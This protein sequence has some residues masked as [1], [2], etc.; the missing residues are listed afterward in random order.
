MENLTAFLKD[1]LYRHGA[2]VVGIG[3][4]AELPPAVREQLPFGVSVAV[5]YPAEVIRGIEA[6]PTA[7]YFDWYNRLN[8]KLDGLVTLG[9]ELLQARGYQ[10]VA[11]TRARAG[12]GD[13][14]R[15]TKLPHKTVATRAGIG[16]VGKSALLV[17]GTYGS[18]IRLS[19]ILTDAPLEAAV[20]IDQS[21]C[22]DCRVCMDAC[23]GAAVSG[24]L[25]EAGCRREAFFDAAKCAKAAL[26]CAK[27]GFGGDMTICGKCI[28]VCP[29]TRRY[30]NPL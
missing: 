25:W 3:D 28:A 7:H 4:L 9:A 24:K 12:T 10:A 18:A 1:E 19:S 29:H 27:K 23:P 11:Q 22:G 6:L 13:S 8:E 17:T 5:K 26:E 20:S 30:L 14:D 2:D 16:W 21:R 15:N